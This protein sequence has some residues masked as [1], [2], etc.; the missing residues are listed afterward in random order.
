MISL[1][2]EILRKSKMKIEDKIFNFS[3]FTFNFYYGIYSNSS[4]ALFIFRMTSSGRMVNARRH[5]Q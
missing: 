5:V 2:S 4:I 3:L 1:R